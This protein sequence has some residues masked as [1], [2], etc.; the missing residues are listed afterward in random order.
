MVV[1]LTYVSR[2]YWGPYEVLGLEIQLGN[3]SHPITDNARLWY[4]IVT[5]LHINI[6]WGILNLMPIYPLDGGQVARELFISNTN[7]GLR[8]SLQ[9]SI[10]TAIVL[11]VL[12]FTRYESPFMAFMF[13][14]LAYLNYQ[15]LS[16]PVGGYRW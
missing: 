1:L 2:R 16:G 12:A 8:M 6:Y 13:G 14:Y 10:V 4:L 5:L 15:Q 11:A 3:S 7:D 9:L